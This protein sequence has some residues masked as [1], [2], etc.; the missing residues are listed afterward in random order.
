MNIPT[1]NEIKFD[2]VLSVIKSIDYMMVRE[3]AFDAWLEEHDRRL[4]AS[5]GIMKP[6]K[7]S[8]GKN[9]SA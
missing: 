7:D 2:Y 5:Y 6:E 4:L 3:Q 1:D 8:N 9:V